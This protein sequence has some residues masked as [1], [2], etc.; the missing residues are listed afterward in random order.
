MAAPQQQVADLSVKFGL[1]IKPIIDAR[2]SVSDDKMTLNTQEILIAIKELSSRLDVIEK[3]CGEKKRPAPTKVKADGAAAAPTAEGTPAVKGFPVNKLV[4]FRDQYKNNEE[5]RAKYATPEI[6]AKMD[7]DAGIQAKNKK[8]QEAQQLT[9]QA[10]YCWNFIK[11]NKPEV[12]A[13]IEEEYTRA[14]KAHEEANKP[15]QET[16]EANSPKKE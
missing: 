6:Q 11:S 12:G 2:A 9:L 15:K 3:V 10:T 14:K 16:A 4:F 5:F 13:E 1:V 8:G 7:L